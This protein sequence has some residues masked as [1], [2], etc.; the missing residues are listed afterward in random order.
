MEN[1]G[2]ALSIFDE[3]GQQELEN[4]KSFEQARRELP[5][6]DHQCMIFCED[7]EVPSY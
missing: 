7:A 4:P 5:P 3:P 2:F 1:G 6:S